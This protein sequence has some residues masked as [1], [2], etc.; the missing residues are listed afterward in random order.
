RGASLPL[1]AK[2]ATLGVGDRQR[3]EIA[4]ALYRDAR[5]LILDEPTAVLTPGEADVL[6]ATLHRLADA[7]RAIVVVTHKLDEVRD[8]ADV[9]SVLRHG[10][11]VMT[12][13]LARGDAD[14][15]RAI[16]E[17]IM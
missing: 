1:D 8:H 11:L 2:V 3:L 13:D 16:A 15:V 9:V 5:I 10:Q 4:R 12:R 6:Y 14:A 17:A 7:G